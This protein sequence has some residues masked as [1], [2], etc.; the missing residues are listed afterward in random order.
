MMY[1]RSEDGLKWEDIDETSMRVTLAGYYHDVDLVV[2]DL[3]Q[4]YPV[5][6][7]F[8]V[9]RWNGITDAEAARINEYEMW[10]PEGRPEGF[11]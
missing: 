11:R 6:T 10:G 8:A 7:P 2:D 4:G 9:Y 1:Q 5:R 3:H